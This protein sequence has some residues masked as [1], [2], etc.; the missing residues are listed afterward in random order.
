MRRN[1]RQATEKAFGGEPLLDVLDRGAVPGA[2]RT[3]RLGLDED[4]LAGRLREGVLD[5]LVGSSGVAGQ[6]L[7]VGGDRLRTEAAADEDGE[8]DE[9]EPYEDG[10]AAVLRAP[11]TGAGGEVLLFHGGSLGRMGH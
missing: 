1:A 2:L 6:A 9:G 3:F 8:D 10:L 7:L 11:A 5:D 4:L